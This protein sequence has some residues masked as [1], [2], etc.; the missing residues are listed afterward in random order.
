[1]AV[2]AVFLIVLTSLW[3]KHNIEISRQNRRRAAVAV[4]QQPYIIDKV[5]AEVEIEDIEVLKNSA[6]IEIT[7]ENNKKMF[8]SISAQ[9][10]NI[11]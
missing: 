1:M 3:I 7:V 9:T 11:E 8:K 4:T 10:G 6:L 2:F 5:G